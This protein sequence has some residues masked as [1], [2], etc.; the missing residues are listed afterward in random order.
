MYSVNLQVCKSLTTVVHNC[1]NILFLH[2]K[3]TIYRLLFNY[4]QINKK[5]KKNY[6][7]KKK[8]PVLFFPNKS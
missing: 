1:L 3:K 6:T 5:S 4:I 8:V 2:K 7:N